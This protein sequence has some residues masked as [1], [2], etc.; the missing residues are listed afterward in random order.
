MS[1]IDNTAESTKGMPTKWILTTLGVF[2]AGLGLFAFAPEIAQKAS[3]QTGRGAGLPF[4]ALL[5]GFGGCTVWMWHLA[6]E[7]QKTYGRF[8]PM[9]AFLMATSFSTLL[10]AIGYGS[11][12]LLVYFGAMRGIDITDR[13]EALEL[14]MQGLEY[15][16]KAKNI[17]GVIIVVWGLVWLIGWLIQGRPDVWSHDTTGNA[18]PLP[19]RPRASQGPMPRRPRPSQGP[20]QPKRF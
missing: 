13:L 4:I 14:V 8:G 2:L 19:E 5:L 12:Y 10:K 9:T 7:R 1:T 15:G 6:R 17:A 3:E 11:I 16:D 20:I 18:K